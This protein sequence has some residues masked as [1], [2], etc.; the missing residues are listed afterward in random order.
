M[1]VYSCMAVC[2]RVYVCL[3]AMKV[4]LNCYKILSI[5]FATKENALRTSKKISAS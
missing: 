4:I 3:Y 5:L 2:V 1:R